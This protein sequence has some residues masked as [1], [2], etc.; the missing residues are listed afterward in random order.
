[1]KRENC[2]ALGLMPEQLTPPT[3]LHLVNTIDQLCVCCGN[4]DNELV[5][6]VITKKG[7]VK[8]KLS[9]SIARLDTAV[10][11]T[12][13]G[14]LY[15]STVHRCDCHIQLKSGVLPAKLSGYH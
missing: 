15:T 12:C 13:D 5:D 1:M 10:P 8:G 6:A 4:P 11:V 2:K 3:F 7:V 14:K 9:T